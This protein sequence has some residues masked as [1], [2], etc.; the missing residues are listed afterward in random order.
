MLETPIRILS[1][2][3]SAVVLLG[4]GLFVIDETGEASRDASAQIAGR[5][6]GTIALP[7][8]QEESVREREHSGA[9]ELVN[10]VNDV[11]LAPFAMLTDD[12]ND[13]WLRRGVPALLGL[14]V[15]GFGL[16]ML[17]RF[18]RGRS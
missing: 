15:Y 18:S 6:V 13:A 5:D 10:D 12:E 11:V 3:L 9:R 8:P 1:I 7:T 17:A 16:G 4:F 2:A 14:L